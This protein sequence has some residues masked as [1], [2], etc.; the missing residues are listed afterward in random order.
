M[1]KTETS[2]EA[3]F[4]RPDFSPPFQNFRTIAAIRFPLTVVYIVAFAAAFWFYSI[5]WPNAPLTVS[6]S[7]S[8]LRAAQDFSHHINQLQERTP[9][10]PLLLLLTG[11]SHSPERMLFFVSLL[12][13]FASIFLLAS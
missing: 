5:C 6:D 9:G 7:T 12:L 1:L 11:S 3:G 8:Y 10:Y 13:H 4:E 2:N